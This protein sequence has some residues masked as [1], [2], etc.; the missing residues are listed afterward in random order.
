MT[1]QE[2]SSCLKASFFPAILLMTVAGAFVGLL[3]KDKLGLSEE[4]TKQL[5]V[6]IVDSFTAGLA[7]VGLKDGSD[8]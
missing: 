7:W 3:L 8:E 2:F 4:T 1:C 6:F 5:A